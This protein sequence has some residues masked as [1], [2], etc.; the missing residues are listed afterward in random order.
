MIDGDWRAGV[1]LTD[2]STG[3]ALIPRDRQH[4]I[5]ISV[6]PFIEGARIN[7]TTTTVLG[8]GFGINASIP[9]GSAREEAAWEL[10]KWLV[11]P[12]VQTMRMNTGG[13]TQP[14]RVDLDV[15]SLDLEPLQI[16]LGNLGSQYDA[17][18]VVI[19]AAFE[20]EVFAPLNEGLQAIGL[21]T[22]SPQ[23]VAEQ[24][25]AAFDTWRARNPL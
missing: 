11:G 4:M 1:F 3:Q 19:D 9:Q 21:G 23:Q 2:P 17:V 6:F 24:V 22:R 7:R 25:Q 10:V 15:G 5:Q 14:I 16:A 8:T 20:A 18:T 13:I 12:E